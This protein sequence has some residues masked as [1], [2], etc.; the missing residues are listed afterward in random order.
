MGFKV[1]GIEID[2]VIVRP[3][4]AVFMKEMEL[5][6]QRRDV[7]SGDDDEGKSYGPWEDQTPEIIW[8][9]LAEELSE[10]FP[11]LFPRKGRTDESDKLV[12]KEAVDVCLTAFFL[13]TN[14]HPE[15]REY[16]KGWPA[17][18]TTSKYGVC[19]KGNVGLL[20]EIRMKDTDKET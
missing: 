15:L 3:S 13:F 12:M 16:K 17:L 20:S 14:R 4:L 6:L 9:K 10:L 7:A 2:G 1:R 19:C 11:V 5:K 18:P 8:M